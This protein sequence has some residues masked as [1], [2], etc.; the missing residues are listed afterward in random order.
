MTDSPSHAERWARL[1]RAIRWLVVTVAF[2]VAFFAWDASLGSLAK[3]WR[4][5]A[6]RLEETAADVH[7][8]ED[9]QTRL[10]NARETIV[11]LGP[12]A[13]PGRDE[14]GR[15]DLTNAVVEVLKGKAYDFELTGGRTRL[16]EE[17]SRGIARPG[18]RLVRL[19]G[20]VKFQASPE[21]AIA[22]ISELESHEAIE[23]ISKVSITKGDS[24]GSPQVD[25]NL[26]VEVWVQEP[27][28]RPRR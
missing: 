9:V 3:E 25:V 5:A 7:A 4:A 18:F 16:R 15:A 28:V 27:I 8:S 1:P 12:V 6:D 17:L 22:I 10:V 23:A 24:R 19:G 14:D 11:A 21:D 26:T 2:I 13:E 20:T